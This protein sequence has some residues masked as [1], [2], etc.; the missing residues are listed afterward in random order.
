MIHLRSITLPSGK[1]GTGF[2]F[3]VPAISTLPTIEFDAPVTFF[4]GENGSGK[5][6]LLESLAI[7]TGLPAVA[8]TST[9]DDETLAP[10]RALASALLLAWNKRTHRGFF[11]RAEDFFGFAKSLSRLREEM[12]QRIDELEKEYR[13]RSAYAR[14]LAM[15]PAAASLGDMEQRY[16]ENLDA[17]SHGQAFFQLF[18]SRFVPGGLYLL[19]EPE[20]PLSPLSQLAFL[21]MLK[22]MTAQDAQFVI[23]T[24]SPILLAHPGARI[25]DFDAQP[26]RW[27][28]YEELEHV[29][30]T[31][32]FLSDPER[33][34]RRL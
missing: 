31:R 2:P 8:S 34:L 28:A 4:V 10:Q 1:R 23:A 11:L 18:R 27:A 7:A 15:G 26:I 29:R 12:Q 19:D 32:E 30:L 6:T 3:S 16:G 5:S 20:T 22:E 13:E 25:L 9:Q 21:S 33:F 14:S 24:H 17:N